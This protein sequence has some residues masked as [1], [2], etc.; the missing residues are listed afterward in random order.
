MRPKLSFANVVSVVALFVALGGS[1]YAFHLGKNSVGSK[2][3]KKNAVT[4]V[5]IKDRAVTAAKLSGAVPSAVN[6]QT[7]GGMSVDQ[8][9]QS[10]KLRCPT[11]T[12]LVASVCFESAAR[13]PE[14]FDAAVETCAAAGRTLASTGEMAAYLDA[15]GGPNNVYYW[16]DTFFLD[17]G[18]FHGGTIQGLG[19]NK[20]L[21]NTG[22][23]SLSIKFL[24]VTPPTN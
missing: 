4:T 8:I 21:I 6:A 10:S 13:S 15:K 11:G 24:C 2:Q 20:L 17:E 18:E 9:T 12:E 22:T 3:L 5:K 19:G 7:L 16:T 14:T 23:A 1:A